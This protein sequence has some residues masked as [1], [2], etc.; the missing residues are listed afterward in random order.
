MGEGKMYNFDNYSQ[1][2]FEVDKAKIY[3][4]EG[5]YSRIATVIPKTKS[6]VKCGYCHGELYVEFSGKTVATS[7]YLG[8]VTMANVNILPA[9]I[10]RKTGVSV[11]LD[12]LLN[13]R[14]TTVD[15]KHDM[16][17]PH[18]IIVDNYI[19]LLREMAF[20]STGKTECISYDKKC[21]F[22]HS[23]LIKPTT[24]TTYDS[25]AI[26]NKYT[27]ILD[28]R[29]N[30]GGYFKSFDTEFLER[31]VKHVIRFERRIRR[32][33]ELRRAF[34][35]KKN[36]TVTLYKI[37]NCKFDVVGEKVNKILGINMEGK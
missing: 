12:V 16:Q 24:K 7:T 28:K 15:V 18:P 17:L 14:V 34:H 8:G 9:I 27:E 21:G 19:S 33:R 26:Y 31:T 6:H 2:L 36:E 11:S 3:L 37:L 10:K 30:D 13:S 35:L 23:I 29:R 25:L 5:S 20:Q 1:Q 22:D 4:A 32:A